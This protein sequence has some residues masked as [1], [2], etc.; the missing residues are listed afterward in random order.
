MKGPV[1][2][3]LTDEDLAALAISTAEVA[4]AIEDALCKAAAGTLWTAPKCA[5]QPGDGRYMM[6]T[7]AASDDPPVMVV[8]SV[9]LN[10]ENPAKGLDAI[11][12]A[13]MV[14]N[15]ETGLLR[16]VMGASWVTGIRTAG[17]SAVAARRLADPSSKVITFVGCGV[18]ARSHLSAFADLF[19]LTEIRAFGR[20]RENIDR[21]C[22]LGRARGLTARRVTLPQEALE[23]ADIVVTSI[24]ATFDGAPFLNAHWLKPGA[25]A[26][27]TDL[28][29]PW[30]P[31]TMQ[32]FATVVI[33]DHTQEKAMPVPMVAPELVSADLTGAVSG[34]EPATFNPARPGAFIFRGMAAGDFAVAALAYGRSCKG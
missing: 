33:D 12:G 14:L 3:Q 8:K 22:D 31:E 23:G 2:L 30:I 9:L 25:F 16:C 20:G 27:I 28:A 10:P 29:R 5:L 17:L 15:S 4:D 26:A 18:Q 1:Y 21:L 13:I 19:P 34:R 24:T 11:N 7:L 6:A 32:A